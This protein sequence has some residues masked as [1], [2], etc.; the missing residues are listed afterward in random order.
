MKRYIGSFYNHEQYKLIGFIAFTD[1]GIK[2][3][4]KM[5]KRWGWEYDGTFSPLRQVDKFPD[6]LELVF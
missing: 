2:H 4:I 1:I 5:A 3:K 6:Y